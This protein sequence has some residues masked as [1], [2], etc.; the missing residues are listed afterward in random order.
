MSEGKK[1]QERRITAWSVEDTLKRIAVMPPDDVFN[2]GKQMAS[3]MPMAA[4][5]LSKGLHDGAPKQRDITRE[6]PTPPVQAAPPQPPQLTPRQKQEML[7][8]QAAQG[9][10][11]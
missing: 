10:Q 9:G 6:P 2:L 8:Q 4:M 1:R 5:L 11:Q 3:E 7:R